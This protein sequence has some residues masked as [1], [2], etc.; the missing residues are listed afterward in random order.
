LKFEGKVLEAETKTTPTEE[1]YRL[2][3]APLSNEMNNTPYESGLLLSSSERIILDYKEEEIE[4]IEN[5]EETR[6]Y[7][8][9]LPDYWGTDLELIKPCA[10]DAYIN[11]FLLFDKTNNMIFIMAHGKNFIPRDSDDNHY[12]MIIEA[13]FQFK[14]CDSVKNMKNIFGYAD[15]REF[16]ELDAPL[17]AIISDQN[18]HL[19]NINLD[20][21]TD[22]SF[23]S[24]E[25][26]RTISGYP[27]RNLLDTITNISIY[28]R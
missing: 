10:R 3:K 6:I 4:K 8:Y 26:W 14:R 28:I 16:A 7:F 18:N 27:G 15:R 11:K 12:D 23:S 2:T 17:R 24:E 13:A 5:E 9:N 22:Y 25:D 21:F 20:D 1:F 19:Y